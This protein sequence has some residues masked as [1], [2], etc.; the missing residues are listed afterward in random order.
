MGFVSQGLC[1]SDKVKVIT[2]NPGEKDPQRNVAIR[3]KLGEYT[4]RMLEV[5]SFRLFWS[6]E[7]PYK[8]KAL[9]FASSA[10]EL[11]A[12]GNKENALTN[13]Q[14]AVAAFLQVHPKF[15]HNIKLIQCASHKHSYPRVR[16]CLLF[17]LYNLGKLSVDYRPAQDIVEK[18]TPT[19]RSY[20][21]RA[22]VLLFL[23]A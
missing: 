20:I 1:W 23:P 11:D 13:Y 12:Q 18:L 9:H 5:D 14:K 2:P 19:M 22:E 15:L 6:N 8:L 16:Y 17:S 21:K 3:S 7:F 10:C 4:V